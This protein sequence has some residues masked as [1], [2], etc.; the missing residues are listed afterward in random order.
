MAFGTSEATR[1]CFPFSFPSQLLCPSSDSIPHFEMDPQPRSSAQS[2]SPM[3]LPC[4]RNCPS[5]G[6]LFLTESSLSLQ[7]PTLA[8]K[9]AYT[10][11]AI[12]FSPMGTSWRI[13]TRS[14]RSNSKVIKSWIRGGRWRRESL[15][16][17]KKKNNKVFLCI[18]EDFTL[19]NICCK[20]YSSG[21]AC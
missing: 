13:C 7:S 16:R 4:D 5:R 3:E 1:F 10:A 9:L 14:W 2:L 19:H 8:W 6:K 21:F 20:E 11:L 15:E 18:V 12:L 17:L